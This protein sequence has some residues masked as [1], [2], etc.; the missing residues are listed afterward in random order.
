MNSISRKTILITGAAGFVGH[1]LVEHLLKNTDYNVIGVDALNY[2]GTWD[3]L[4]D[5]KLEETTGYDHPRFT[6]ITY[7]F[8]LPAE[9]NL[10]KELQKVTHVMHLGA[11][12]HVD[13]SISDPMRF[14][15]ANVVGTTNMLNLARQLPN[16][17][18]FVYFSTDEVFGPAP[19]DSQG[20]LGF[21]EE[22]LHLPK[23]PYAATKSAAEKLVISFA[24]TYKLP[25]IITRQMNIFG[26]RQHAEKFIPL[27]INRTINGGHIEI[28]GTPDKSKAGLR[29]YIHARNVADAHLFLLD[30]KPWESHDVQHVESYHIV[31]EQEV[32][33]LTL[34]KLIQ[35]YTQI[36]CPKYDIV[37]MG[38]T[39]EIVDFHSSRPGHDLRYALDGT[40]MKD[41]GWQPPKTF[42]ESLKKSIEWYLRNPQWLT[43][44]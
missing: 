7:D 2:S 5:C 21:S 38:F 8:R 34:A 25:C 29:S 6:P 23:N 37:P 10:V 26:E 19:M 12:S 4:R 20:F 13:H 43:T 30:E 31:G 27:C 39:M 33:N 22:D 36:L 40:K 44:K 41:L 3:R 18:L 24:N 32:D 28:H 16:L 1:H 15:E 17:E 35:E 11:E 14:V 9:P 42:Q